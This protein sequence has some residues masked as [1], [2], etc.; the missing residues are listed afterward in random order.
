MIVILIVVER[1]LWNQIL[2]MLVALKSVDF[3]QISVNEILIG[4]PYFKN[5]SE[6]QVSYQFTLPKKKKQ[7]YFF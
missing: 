3:I 6:T 7:P 1:M 5:S 4:K 2:V